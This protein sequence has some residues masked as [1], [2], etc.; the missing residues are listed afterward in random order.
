MGDRDET[1]RIGTAPLL[2]TAP[3]PDEAAMLARAEAARASL[4]PISPAKFDE[5]ARAVA[6]VWAKKDDLADGAKAAS[7]AKLKQIEKELTDVALP[8]K[9]GGHNVKQLRAI[10]QRLADEWERD[11][12][13]VGDKALA[14]AL[15][16]AG[17][18]VDAAV[19]IMG[20]NPIDV[21]DYDEM[22]GV[23]AE[24][25]DAAR[26]LYADQIKVESEDLK[27]RISMH[28]SLGALGAKDL[29]DVL[30]DIRDELYGAAAADPEGELDA[31]T[32]GLGGYAHRAAMILRTEIGRVFG[33]AGEAFG[34][35]F[36]K[37][38][39]RMRKVWNATDDE[40]TRPGHV[41]A[42]ERYSEDKLANCPRIGEPFMVPVVR[43]RRKKGVVVSSEVV[44]EE[45]LMF[46]GDPAG[47]AENSCQCRCV[48]SHVDPAWYGIVLPGDG[49]EAPDAG[50][51]DQTDET[52]ETEA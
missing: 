20:S 32:E 29:G 5:Y 27:R 44:R 1:A 52:D 46:P 2:E 28:V 4:K 50:E 12:I 25:L 8:G 37:S 22:G 15:D 49:E 21:A 11:L 31:Q 18:P 48:I 23:G 6:D 14:D 19:E 7:L 41:M 40:R 38:N 24:L 16:L 35:K 10:I 51:E 3:T 39:P 47:S 26:D 36:L 17:Q 13:D 42:G 45:K 30:S 33:G 43:E 9:L 34:A